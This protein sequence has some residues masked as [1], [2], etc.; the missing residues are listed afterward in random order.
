MDSRRLIADEGLDN[1][2]VAVGLFKQ[3]RWNQAAD[4]FR[5]FLKN[6][7]KHEKAP[8]ARLYLGLTLVENKDF[9]NARE[10]LRKFVSENRQ[11][12]NLGQARY[13]LANAAICSMTYRQH[14]PSWKDFF[15]I[16]RKIR[17]ESM[18]TL[19]WVIPN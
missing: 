19:I 1:Y 2:N 14:E 10:E 4:Q 16:S 15:G 11:N 13:G 17:C 12:P 3:N 8:V 18:R 5:K 9:K 7:E 6:Y